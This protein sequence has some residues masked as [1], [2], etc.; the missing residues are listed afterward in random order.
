MNRIV[1]NILRFLIVVLLQVL[2]LNNI[3]F[4]PLCTPYIYVF[5][6]LCLPV[7]IPRW[8][9]ILIGFATGLIMDCFCNTVGIHA[10]AC[11][12]VCYLRQLSIRWFVDNVD[13]LQGTPSAFSFLNFAAYIKY[14]VLLVLV[15]HGSVILLDAFTFHHLWW[16]MLQIIVSSAITIVIIV[17]YDIIRN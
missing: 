2:V 15:H 4:I 8:A 13:R 11:T 5:F 3:Q 16:T 7:E 1:E 17:T 9:D 12:A 6:L 10:F 14:V